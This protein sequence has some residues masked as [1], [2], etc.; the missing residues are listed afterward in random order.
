MYFLVKNVIKDLG[1]LNDDLLK[2]DTS[3]NYLK[4]DENLYRKKIDLRQKKK[5]LQNAKK[6]ML[7]IL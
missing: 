1:L 6:E 4:E 2:T 3:E 5:L 7:N